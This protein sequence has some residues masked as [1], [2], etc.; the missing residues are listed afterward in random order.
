MSVQTIKI[1]IAGALLLHG[2]GHVGAI[3]A[4]VAHGLGASTGSLAARSVLAV[5]PAP[6]ARSRNRG[7]YLLGPICHRI[8]GGI[9]VVLGHPRPRRAMEATGPCFI[10]RL[11]PRYRAL[12]WNMAPVQHIRRPGNEHRG[13]GH[14]T[15]HALASTVHVWKVSV[16][17]SV[18]SLKGS[19]SMGRLTKGW[20]RGQI[21]A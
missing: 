12:L 1:L 10:R 7:Q 4:L 19:S 11:H 18:C 17:S 5:T 6:S 15:L 9:H 3:G 8:R 21:A 20:R 13:P 16:S 14:S 2:L